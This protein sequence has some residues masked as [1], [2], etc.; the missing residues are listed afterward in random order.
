MNKPIYDK[1]GIP[2]PEENPEFYA[3]ITN[4]NYAHINV[5]MIL[6]ELRKYEP[7]ALNDQQCRTQLAK[8]KAF[9]SMIDFP[10]AVINK[11]EDDGS[12]DE[13]RD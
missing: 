10:H 12:T 9:Q 6:N 2:K 5:L 8:L 13:L 3:V 1:S 11:D 4:P 7:E